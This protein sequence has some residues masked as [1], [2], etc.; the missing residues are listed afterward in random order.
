MRTHLMPI[1]SAV[2]TIAKTAIG[3]EKAS[4]VI[5]GKAFVQG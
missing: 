1:A 3:S 5:R 2:L 4:G